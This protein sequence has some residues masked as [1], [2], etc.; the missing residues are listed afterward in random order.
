MRRI[1]TAFLLG[2]AATVALAPLAA[3]DDDTTVNTAFNDAGGE[4]GEGG[5][6]GKSE[7]GTAPDAAATDAA[8]TDANDDGG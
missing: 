1:A 4:G 3:C 2:A 8:A 6:G 5:E 7:G